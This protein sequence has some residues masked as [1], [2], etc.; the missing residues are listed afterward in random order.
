MKFV[1]LVPILLG[2]TLVTE[3]LWRPSGS[4]GKVCRTRR[5]MTSGT[6]GILTHVSRP[7]G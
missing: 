2:N 1:K 6:L 5:P 7:N 3:A 4:L